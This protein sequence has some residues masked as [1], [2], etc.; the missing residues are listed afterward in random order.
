MN[1][2]LET[3]K[4]KHKL[5]LY[6]PIQNQFPT[7]LQAWDFPVQRT[8][9]TLSSA[10]QHYLLNKHKCYDHL[11]IT[12]RKAWFGLEAGIYCEVQSARGIIQS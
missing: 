6:W 11:S 2:T 9:L 12:S 7:I 8:K 5:S 3:G 4:K 10:E 1:L